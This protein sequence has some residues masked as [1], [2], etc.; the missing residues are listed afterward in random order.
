MGTVEALLS[1]RQDDYG[2]CVETHTRMAGHISLI[3]GVPVTAR[4]AALCMVA[5]KLA[6][7]SH[8]HKDDNCDDGG[9]YFEIAKKCAHAEAAGTG[10]HRRD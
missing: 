8:Q 7:E 1:E 4:Q 3:L 6:R 10:K 5:V 2:D 9:S